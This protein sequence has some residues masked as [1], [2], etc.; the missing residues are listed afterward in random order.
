MILVVLAVV[1]VVFM[2]FAFVIARGAP[3]LPTLKQQTNDALDLL[4]L[5]KGQTLLELGSGDGRLMRAAAERGVYSVGYELNPLLV[6]YS[7]LRHWRYR[8]Y[9]TVKWADFWLAEWP[10]SDGM[11]VFLLQKY[12]KK[13]DNKV[14]QYSKGK[15]YKLVSF[16]F[17][18][19]NKKAIKKLKGVCLYTYN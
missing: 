4:D 18:I 10:E 3:Y 8:R 9:M 16:G 11:Y 17:E 6:L 15:N 19:P 5:K 14:I 7:R 1:F 2:L 13:L 12:M